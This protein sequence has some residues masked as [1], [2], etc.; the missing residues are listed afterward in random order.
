MRR[1]R[2]AVLL[3]LAVACASPETAEE[4]APPPLTA[5][6]VLFDDP[7]LG[8][9][10]LCVPWER[11]EALRGQ[12]VAFACSPDLLSAFPLLTVAL[13]AFRHG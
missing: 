12:G 6:A 8:P 11:F 3:L 1:V 10:D 7:S 13:D 4:G 2:A 9:G 5:P